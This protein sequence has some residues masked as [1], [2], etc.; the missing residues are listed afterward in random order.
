MVKNNP[1]QDIF[2]IQN[3]IHSKSTYLKLIGK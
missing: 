2:Q 3:T 1:E